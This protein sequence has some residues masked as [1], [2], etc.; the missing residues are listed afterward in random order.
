MPGENSIKNCPSRAV[1]SPRH[2]ESALIATNTSSPDCAYFCQHQTHALFMH[3][4]RVY[5]NISLTSRV[6]SH[7]NAG[8]GAAQCGSGVKEPLGMLAG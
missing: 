8:C 6:L 3:S 5:D 1:R 7:R 4:Y 2:V